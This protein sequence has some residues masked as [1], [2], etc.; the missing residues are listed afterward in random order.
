MTSV[1]IKM[2]FG[3][4][5]RLISANFNPDCGDSGGDSGELGGDDC[6]RRGVGG[7]RFDGGNGVGLRNGGGG[8][9]GMCEKSSLGSKVKSAKTMFLEGAQCSDPQQESHSILLQSLLGCVTCGAVQKW[10]SCKAF[11]LS[12]RSLKVAVGVVEEVVVVEEV[13]RV[14]R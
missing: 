1:D 14:S 13:R 10:S 6:R 9:V 2:G 8:D 3:L 4:C 12:F 5:F 7:E 11:F